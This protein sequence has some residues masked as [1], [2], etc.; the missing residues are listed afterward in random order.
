MKLKLKANIK[1][2]V[3]NIMSLI[4]IS[5]NAL[6]KLKTIFNLHNKKYLAFGIK[7]GGCS[8]FQY[9]IKPCDLEPNKLDEI[10]KI[11]ELK[12]KVDNDSLLHIIGTEIDWEDD[13][14]GQR[15]IFKNPNSNF[16]CGCGKSFS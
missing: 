13:F 7:S 11:D 6:P 5:K 3:I 2:S 4:T 15:F 8:G 12:I 16:Q 14:M 9:D 10:V 1:I